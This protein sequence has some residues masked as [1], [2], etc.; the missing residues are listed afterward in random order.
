ML[1]HP[2]MLSY[3][4]AHLMQPLLHHHLVHTAAVVVLL[5][6]SLEVSPAGVLELDSGIPSPSTHQWHGSKQDAGVDVGHLRALQGNTVFQLL[7]ALSTK[8]WQVATVL[9]RVLTLSSTQ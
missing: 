5:L 4:S 1:S 2:A 8:S 9:L 3:C 7:L 6:F